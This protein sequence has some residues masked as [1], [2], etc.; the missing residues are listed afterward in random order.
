MMKSWPVKT[1]E[2]IRKVPRGTEFNSATDVSASLIWW[3]IC[4]TLR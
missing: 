2:W 4:S 3:R 1:R